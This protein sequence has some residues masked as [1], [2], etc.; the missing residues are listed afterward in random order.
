MA[1]YSYGHKQI[2]RCLG[3]KRFT[4][5]HGVLGRRLPPQPK[6]V[7]QQQ[8]QDQGLK[9]AIGI[10]T[11]REVLLVECVGMA[12]LKFEE[13]MKNATPTVRLTLRYCVNGHD[14]SCT[15][16]EWTGITFDG[17]PRER[18][19]EILL[20]FGKELGKAGDSGVA[21][22]GLDFRQHLDAIDRE[23]KKSRY[24]AFSKAQGSGRACTHEE[25]EGEKDG[26]R[27]SHNKESL[28][29]FLMQLARLGDVMEGGLLRL[30]EEMESLK[31]DTRK[32]CP[33]EEEEE[34]PAPRD[35]PDKK[36]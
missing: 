11:H 9:I 6:P 8:Q 12:Q 2:P 14:E 31:N 25:E 7:A 15:L 23:L 33:V 17:M 28:V 19:D 13:L 20:E 29:Q 5:V 26:A 18:T 24:L 4:P 16:A 1:D 10:V 22:L 3:G 32:H 36:E 35:D 21:L 27:C 34:G 30:R